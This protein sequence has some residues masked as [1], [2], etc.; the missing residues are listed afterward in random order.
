MIPRDQLPKMT[1]KE[2]EE[3]IR[4]QGK[5]PGHTRVARYY[6]GNNITFDADPYCLNFH[7]TM[8]EYLL[9]LHCAKDIPNETRLDIFTFDRHGNNM[10][11]FQVLFCVEKQADF[12]LN[13][14][15]K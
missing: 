6:F 3:T 9:L 10:E 14:N 2:L 12:R 1:H 7:P 13:T 11:N 5:A 15:S 8:M 4:K